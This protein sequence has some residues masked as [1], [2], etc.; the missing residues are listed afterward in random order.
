MKSPNLDPVGDSGRGIGAG[1]AGRSL[2]HQ[3]RSLAGNGPNPSSGTGLR[4]AEPAPCRSRSPCP[5]GP[6]PGMGFTTSGDHANV[7]R[8]GATPSPQ[9][10]AIASG[11]RTETW[12]S[13]PCWTGIVPVAETAQAQSFDNQAEFVKPIWDYAKSAVS[14]TR[15]SNGHGQAGGEC[16][17]VRQ[18][19]RRSTPRRA[20]SSAAIWG[21]ESSLWRRSSA[22]K[23]R[24]ACWPA[25]RRS[26]GARISTSSELDRRDEADRGW[27]RRPATSFAQGLMGGRASDRRSS[28]HPASSTYGKDHDGDGH[29][30]LWSNSGD[31]L[32]SARNYLQ[33]VRLEEG[34]ALGR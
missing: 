20:K 14:P 12:F 31:A 7:R 8:R 33:R 17:R 32:A 10:A 25:R 24:R 5:A 11:R 29:K 3:Q 23:T 6:H 9:K 34:T 27:R 19:W 28:C 22:M 13:Q 26:A 21:M 18:P 1:S 15:I 2:R 16:R 4:T 30:D